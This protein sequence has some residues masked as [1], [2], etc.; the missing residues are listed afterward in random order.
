MS[1]P[2]STLSMNRQLS[3]QI[4]KVQSELAT[5]G[6]ELGSGR[7]ADLPG[8]LKGQYAD[9]IDM[10]A[11]F[12]RL[13]SQSR[14]LDAFN[15]AAQAKQMIMG[16][17]SASVQE[18]MASMAPAI[19]DTATVSE[20]LPNLARQLIDQVTDLLNTADT[21]GY[22]FSG[23][24]REA[25]PILGATEG[26]AP[27]PLD[28]VAGAAVPNPP[29]TLADV[30]ALGASFDTLFDTPSFDTV[31][32][33]G[34]VGTPGTARWTIPIGLQTSLDLGLQANDGAIR[35]VLQGLHMIASVDVASLP[36]E[37]E[38]PLGDG[39][40]R[41][42]P[43]W[44]FMAHAH[45]K[46]A[47][48]ADA[49]TRAQGDLGREQTTAQSMR[50]VLNAQKVLLNGSINDL[51]RVDPF[52]AQVQFATLQSQLEQSFQVTAR[53]ASLSLSNYL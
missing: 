3:S 26:P 49:L 38:A 22:L 24:A 1:D 25:R 13:D 2:L 48:G 9:L 35:D 52:E 17:V 29:A 6:E 39:D 4:V 51:E 19:S 12:G 47:A 7:H 46:I 15:R 18:F 32:Y 50:S 40:A 27:T 53:L 21:D 20:E 43:Y 30:A 23:I 16:E 42:S 33:R 11:E 8:V 41:N 31:F 28:V 45:D 37:P 34:A 36:N 5:K 44:A 14:G 10:R